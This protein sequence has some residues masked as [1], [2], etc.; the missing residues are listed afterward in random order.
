MNARAGLARARRTR[1]LEAASAGM[2][3][4]VA[5][6]VGLTLAGTGSAAAPLMRQK[7]VLAFA[8]FDRAVDALGAAAMDQAER[9]LLS[10]RRFQPAMPAEL[11]PAPTAIR[12]LEIADGDTLADLLARAG[13]ETAEAHAVIRALRP[14]YDLRRLKIGQEV[15]LTFAEAAAAA[16]EQEAKPRL[17]ELSLAASPEQT[18]VA[19]LADGAFSAEA[20]S[21]PLTQASAGLAADIED[22]LYLSAQRA[23]APAPVILELIRLYSYDVDFQRDLQPGDRIEA[24]Y[25][26]QLDEDGELVKTGEI[27]AARFNVKGAE[28]PLYRFR[29]PDGTVDWFDAAGESVRKA[30]LKTPVDGARLSSGFGLRRHPILGYSLMHRGVDFAAPSGTPVMAAGDGVIELAGTNGGYGNYVRLRHDDRH[31]TAYAHL[32]RFAPGLKPGRRVKQGEVIGFVGTTGRSTGPH[33]HYEVMVGGDQVN[34]MGL[35]LPTGRKLDG[36]LL[37]DFR[38]VRND[39][40]RRLAAVATPTRTAALEE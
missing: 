23:G 9:A 29:L 27:L 16:S 18:V 7:T 6:L 20:V 1:R 19:R 4:L 2:G 39:L 35:K 21:K 13:A 22:S 17:V 25:E 14:L 28:L 12:V 34:P 24:V 36:K 31:R 15:T 10:L 30:L 5:G 3:L 26:T 11:A 32:S 40:D 37:A 38:R 33:L 8:D